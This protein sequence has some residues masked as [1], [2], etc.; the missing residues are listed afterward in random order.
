MLSFVTT[1][2]KISYETRLANPETIGHN[3]DFMLT[4][5]SRLDN[6]FGTFRFAATYVNFLL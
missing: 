3:T 2:L 4:V 5:S 1:N 6:A